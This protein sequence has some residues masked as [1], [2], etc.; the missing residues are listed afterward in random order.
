MNLKASKRSFK[1]E[2]YESKLLL[3]LLCHWLSWQSIVAF[4][5]NK[6]VSCDGLLIGVG[7]VK[8][9]EKY[10]SQLVCRV[11]QENSIYNVFT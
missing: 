6:K 5:L 3:S 9:F 11:R 8:N 7:G 2:K 10:I 1:K 4:G